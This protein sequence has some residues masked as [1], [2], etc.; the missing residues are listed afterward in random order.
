MWYLTGANR[1]L[2]S[3]TRLLIHVQKRFVQVNWESLIFTKPLLNYK[4]LWIK[5]SFN[6]EFLL[7][8]AI[9]DCVCYGDSLGWPKPYRKFYSNAHTFFTRIFTRAVEKSIS[10]V[11]WLALFNYMQYGIDIFKNHTRFIFKNKSSHYS[12]HNESKFV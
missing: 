3:A 9:I 5:H 1:R 7:T 2:E 12:S 6:A 11:I 10:L 8:P 4:F